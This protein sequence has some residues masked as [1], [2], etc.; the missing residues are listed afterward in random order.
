MLTILHPELNS[1]IN[2]LVVGLLPILLPEEAP[3][4][5]V[6]TTK[7]MLLTAKVNKSFSIYVAPLTLS[8]ARTLGLISA[9]FDNEDEP[10]T[11]YTPLFE[12]EFTTKLI[13]VLEALSFDVHF[14]DEHGQEWLGYSSVATMSAVAQLRLNA[15]QLLPYTLEFAKEAHNQLTRWFSVRSTLDDKDAIVV[16][17]QHDL[18]PE[19]L[20]VMDMRV[21]RHSFNGS[22]NYSFNQ[23][24][25]KEPGSFQE[26]DIA[27]L[28]GR[29]FLPERLFLNPLRSDNGREVCDLIVVTDDN[30]ILVQAKDSPNTEDVL[31][32]T[33]SRKRSTTR[34]ALTR[35]IDQA[36]GAIRHV[37]E[38]ETFTFISDDRVVSLET[39]SRKIRILLVVKE[40]FND[41]FEWYSSVVL[42]LAREATVPCIVLDYP[43]LYMYSRM[44]GEAKFLEAYDRVYHFGLQNGELPRL[45]IWL[46][47]DSQT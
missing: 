6:K 43:E 23:L 9:F 15:S 33:L 45:R 14:F 38:K 22:G 4:L 3:K 31:R 19:D 32:N 5:V 29:L 11:I 26:R 10:L 39:E 25:R 41:E 24:E 18:V 16:D 34:K 13:H 47:P 37:R 46:E 44:S 36:K 27:N 40:L 1:E 12:D 8:N 7:E 28:L 2:D 42:G 20:F 35:A 17:L 21:E 30:L